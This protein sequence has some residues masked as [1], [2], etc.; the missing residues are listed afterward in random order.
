MSRPAAL[1]VLLT[2]ARLADIDVSRSDTG[3][4]VLRAPKDA[5]RLA[6]R[7]RHRETHV[8]AL[9]D[10]SHAPLGE[11]R[12]C[13]LCRKPAVLRDPAEGRPCHK[14]CCDALLYRPSSP[15]D[16]QPL[17]DPQWLVDDEDEN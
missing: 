7:L 2:R 8:L 4:L 5:V 3:K 1:V 11:R 12:P 15:A 14:A 13:V 10:W 9:Y 17:L 16:R 6:T